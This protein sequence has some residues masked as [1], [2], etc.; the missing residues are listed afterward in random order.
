MKNVVD[1]TES[2][3][4]EPKQHDTLFWCFYIAKY[5]FNEYELI[6]FRPFQTEK[7]FKISSVDMI[8]QKSD[9]LKAIKLKVHDVE[10]E[11]VNESKIT[12]K[13]LR[14]LALVHN[15][16]IFYVSGLTY[17]EFNHGNDMDSSHG[18]IICD[19][20]KNR[21][22]IRYH[23]NTALEYMNKIRASHFHISNPEKPMNA[24]SGYTLKELQHICNK[25]SIPILC[26]D[27]KKATKKNIYEAIMVAV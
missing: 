4:F 5:G 8:R 6:K 26:S 14:A 16:S 1:K 27:G 15:V 2:R 24:I 20:T 19:R 10:N 22:S 23:D 11:L 9:A 21:M 25:L 17:C 7:Q 12:L 13:G 3:M 18:I